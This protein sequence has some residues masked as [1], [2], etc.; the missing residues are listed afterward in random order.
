MIFYIYRR[1]F[2]KSVLPIAN[3]L[4]EEIDRRVEAAPLNESVVL[5]DEAQAQVENLMNSTTYPNFLKSD[6]YLQYV[7]VIIN[8]RYR[9]TVVIKCRLSNCVSWSRA[10]Y[11]H[12]KFNIATFLI[13]G[14]I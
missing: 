12:H 9:Y 7:R 4:R 6:T 11:A 2:L 1:F 10:V 14:I 13:S 8:L 3:E 5:L